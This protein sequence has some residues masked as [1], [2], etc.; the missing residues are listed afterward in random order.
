MRENGARDGQVVFMNVQSC[1]RSGSRIAREL[2]HA[3][4]AESSAPVHS[5]QMLIHEAYGS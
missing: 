3:G 5:L 2:H 1:H 4:L